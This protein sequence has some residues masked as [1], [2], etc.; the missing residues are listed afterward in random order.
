M[1]IDLSKIDKGSTSPTGLT[2][3]KVVAVVIIISAVGVRQNSI[4]IIDVIVVG[5]T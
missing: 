3:A 1:G 2:E 5:A 4:F